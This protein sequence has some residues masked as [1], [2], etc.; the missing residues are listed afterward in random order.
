MDKELQGLEFF[1]GI[2]QSAVE[3]ILVVDADG[4]IIKA[5]P[6]SEELFGYNEDG[7]IAHNIENLIPNKFKI[8]HKSHREGYIV[9][10]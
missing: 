10:P 1:Q 4:I 3:G 7:L 5:N 8:N 9:K 2:F 6:A